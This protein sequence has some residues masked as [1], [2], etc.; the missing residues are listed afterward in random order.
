MLCLSL[1]YC[2]LIAEPFEF[3]AFAGCRAQIGRDERK[4]ALHVVDHV[5]AA[6]VDVADQNAPMGVF[7]D[8]HGLPPEAQDKNLIEQRSL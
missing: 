7:A 3:L 8:V 1:G 6:R 2:W 4:G 5:A